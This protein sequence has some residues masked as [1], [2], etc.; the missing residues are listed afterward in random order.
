LGD[1][2]IGSESNGV[3]MQRYPFVQTTGRVVTPTSVQTL[4]SGGYSPSKTYDLQYRVNDY[5]DAVVN[6]RLYLSKKS[7]LDTNSVG[8]D[9]WLTEIADTTILIKTATSTD[10]AYTFDISDTLKASTVHANNPYM[11]KG[12]YYVYVNAVDGDGQKAVQKSSSYIQV[13]HS[14]SSG[15]GTR[16]EID[17]PVSGNTRVETRDQKYL[18][19]NWSTTGLNDLDDVAELAIYYDTTTAN[20][21]TN[22]SGLLASTTAKLITGGTGGFSLTENDSPPDSLQFTWDLSAATSSL[23]PISNGYYDFYVLVRDEDDTVMAQSRG[24]VQF[25][26]SPDLDFKFNLGGALAKGEGT[27]VRQVV[28]NK[29]ETFRFSWDGSDLDQS[30][31]VRLVVSR[32]DNYNYDALTFPDETGTADAWIV[33]ST[34]GTQTN[35][36][37]VGLT[38]GVYNWFS[39]NMTEMDSVDGDYYVYAFVS[40]DA[41]SS[42]WSNSTTVKFTAE[43]QFR[44]TGTESTSNTD[45]DVQLVPSI[46]TTNKSD[47]ARVYVYVDTK[48]ETV[49]EVGFHIK[50][51]T[52]RF[53]IIDQNS[54]ESGTQPFLV[55]DSYFMSGSGITLVEDSLEVVVAV[56]GD[57]VTPAE[58]YYNLRFRKIDPAVSGGSVSS[59]TVIASFLLRSKGTDSTT[60]NYSNIYFDNE[61]VTVSNNGTPR[62]ISVPTPAAKV[63]TNPLGRIRGRIQLQGRDYF[64]NT[65]TVELRP[66]GSGIAITDS[67]YK[68]AND[69]VLT[70]NGVQ[71][72]MDR[73]GFFE[74][75]KVPTGTYDLVVK[76]DGW[77]SGQRRNIS[78]VPGDLEQG[79]D[80]HFDN[81]ADP[82]DRGYLYAG[83]VSSGD[84]AGYPDNYVDEDDITYMAANYGAIPTGLVAK[85]DLNGN[86][87]VDF[88]DLSWVSL[89]VGEEGV[90]PVYNKNSGGDNALAYLKLNGIPDRT[91]RDQEFEL[92]VWAKN[93]NDLR[94]YTFTMC[95]D[96]D[97]IEIMNEYMA[98]EEGD[99]LVSGNPSNR[100]IFFTIQNKKGIEFVN[101][102]M[103]YV[104][105]AIGEGVI[106]TIKMKSLVDGERPDI[107][108]VDIKVANSVNR[109]FRL[110]DVSQVPDEFGL[111]QNYPNPFNPETRIKFQL[112]MT[113]K[114]VL[115]VYNVLGQE[116]RTLVNT[117]MKA[118]FHSIVWDGR[119][120]T[121]VRVASGIYIYRIK[122]GNFVTSKKMTLLK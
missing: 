82:V 92:Q 20:W 5:D 81:S 114:V 62:N 35:A 46:F 1:S 47:T 75:V 89:N 102:L 45:Y 86:G 55:E 94:G 121:G 65:A 84:A 25:I 30:Q 77:L 120:Q 69:K 90:P 96:P 58:V 85:C 53:E 50:I 2:V 29:G 118:G 66:Y 64:V 95:Y 51:D 116:V 76:V 98:I 67:E 17:R 101:V 26:H 32:Q 41:N 10:S 112:P 49:D 15:S 106:A 109:F 6:V 52:S 87:E 73:D 56:E 63:Y 43:G 11:I 97:K 36:R 4:N 70:T 24:D 107:S 38:S 28:I 22:V 27:A 108:V 110:K 113:S 31:Y 19:I 91:F 115:K 99:F 8:V 72:Y 104:E 39:G 3:L 16:F 117:E 9:G 79:M 119:N 100:S 7:D 61:N 71:V 12:N 74:L 48:G 57:S 105:P 34:D 122:A 54:T 18:T 23:L 111:S 21:G 37:V 60:T 68:D 14:P 42:T 13:K 88:E 103:G 33:N 40:T 93:I 83:D 80:P 44:L 59:D 78:I